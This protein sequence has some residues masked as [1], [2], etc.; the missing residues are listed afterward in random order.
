MMLGFGGVPFDSLH[1]HFPSPHSVS[2]FESTALVH[3]LTAD[4]LNHFIRYVEVS[5]AL[6]CT[7]DQLQ[8]RKFVF[9]NFIQNPAD[10]VERSSA[11]F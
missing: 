4:E 3:L 5:L 10:I 11:I 6:H 2:S 7:P 9:I 1:F 8:T